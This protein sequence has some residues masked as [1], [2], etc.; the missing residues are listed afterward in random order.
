VAEEAHISGI[1]ER[2]ARAI[3]ELAQEHKSVEKI[4]RDLAQLGAMIA[5]SADLARLVRSPVFSREEQSR[6]LDAILVKMDADP[7]TARFVLL[8]A[9]KRRLYMLPQ[10]I[11]G[12]AALVADQKGEIDAEVASA[13]TLHD[14]ELAELK[15]VLKSRLGREP[16]I[17]ARVDPTLLG[18]LVVKIG[19]RMIDSSLRAKLN[20][21]RT[22]MRG[23]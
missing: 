3:F 8:L 19:S 15:A 6:G 5:Q 18:G 13:R 16:Q 7:L 4:G 22:A 21:L 23:A 10:A 17:A 20:A 14:G 9:A 12:Y 1:A 2:Y 11:R